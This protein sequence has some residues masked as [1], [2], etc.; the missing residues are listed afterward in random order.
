MVADNVY[1][2]CATCQLGANGFYLDEG[3]VKKNRVSFDLKDGETVPKR[4]GSWIRFKKCPNCEN[5]TLLK[6]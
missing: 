6:A 2:E 4:K 5:R 1:F 3:K